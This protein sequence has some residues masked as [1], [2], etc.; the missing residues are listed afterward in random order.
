MPK[1]IDL[2][3]QKF[4]RLTVLYR[5]TTR[6]GTYWMCQCECGNLKSI[7]R[8]TLRDGRA[9]SCGCLQRENTSKAN[10]KNLVGQKIG[11]LTVIERDTTKTGGNVYWLCKCDCGNPELISVS[12]SHLG[13]ST[14]SCGCL[15]K[16]RT[17]EAHLINLT[18]QR[19]GKLIVLERDSKIVYPT[20]WLCKCDCGNIVSVGAANLRSGKT[21]SCGCINSKG[22]EA[23]SKILRELDIKYVPQKTFEGLRGNNKP[24]RFDF[25]LPEYKI[26]LEYQGIQHYEPRFGSDKNG[27]FQ[28]QQEYD[29]KKVKYCENNNIKLITIPYTDLKKINKE[30]LLEKIK[31]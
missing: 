29:R 30:Y 23:I 1:L 26:C 24:L 5:D 17:S 11:R 21:E 22:E 8:S 18:N 2:T 27:Y 28:I 25:Y 20:H 15:Q 31:N 6:K 19:F 13:K 14:L 4:G 3:G 7:P 9:K 16:E 12:S 10:T